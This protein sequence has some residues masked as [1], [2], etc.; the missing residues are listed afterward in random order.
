M[1]LVSKCEGQVKKIDLGVASFS[2]RSWTVALDALLAKALSL[3][4]NCTLLD[5]ID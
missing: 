1:F 3:I 4:D 2:L 5:R